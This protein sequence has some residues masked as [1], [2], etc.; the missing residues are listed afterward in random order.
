M[1]IG[2][3]LQLSIRVGCSRIAVID[4]GDAVPNENAFLQ[5]DAFADE[6]VAGNLATGPNFSSLLNLYERTN[7][8]L[9]PDLAAVKIYKP[10]DLDI[11]PQLHVRRDALA[12]DS[13]LRHPP[14]IPTE[15]ATPQFAGIVDGFILLGLCSNVIG[16]PFALSD[17]EAASRIRTMSNPSCP[18]VSGWAPL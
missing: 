7:L 14:E 10:A 8:G 13:L 3:G 2:V 5:R 18:L 1:P 12:I 6:S 15:R 4:E 17:A 9:I 16:A 11:A